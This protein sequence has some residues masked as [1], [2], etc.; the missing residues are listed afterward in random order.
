MSDPAGRWGSPFASRLGTW[1]R[2]IGGRVPVGRI[3]RR[4]ALIV[5]FAVVPPTLLEPGTMK[6][7]NS[8]TIFIAGMEYIPRQP[9]PKKRCE[10]KQ[11]DG[12]YAAW[13]LRLDNRRGIPEPGRQELFIDWQWTDGKLESVQVNKLDKGKLLHRSPDS[14]NRFPDW[15]AD[16]LRPWDIAAR[17]RDLGDQSSEEVILRHFCA[18]VE[19]QRELR[20][21]NTTFVAVD[22]LLARPGA[23]DSARRLADFVTVESDAAR[24]RATPN[25]QL[26][27]VWCAVD[28]RLDTADPQ[29]KNRVQ[30]AIL[31][32]IAD[33]IGRPGQPCAS[34]AGVPAWL[35]GLSG[36]LAILL[37]LAAA[38]LHHRYIRPWAL[39]GE[40][41]GRG[42]LPLLTALRRGGD[43]NDA[44]RGGPPANT[45]SARPAADQS[46][47]PPPAVPLLEGATKLLTR[48]IMPFPMD[49]LRAFADPDLEPERFAALKACTSIDM[50]AETLVTVFFEGLP[51]PP[52]RD[53][54]ENL[55]GWLARES[56]GRLRLVFPKR[57]TPIDDDWHTVV[58]Q[59]FDRGIRG[60]VLA[61]QCPGLARNGKPVHKAQVS[62]T[63]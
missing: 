8:A 21:L 41:G 49:A 19:A 53:H 33:G 46:S 24:A 12:L 18:L 32:R 3:G 34:V 6:G 7:P 23:P 22:A 43:W 2:V 62:I 39:L 58:H 55:D 10:K 11:F 31:R 27:A 47:R 26:R 40:K 63:L 51:Q 42:V 56:R 29:L 5:G 50:F 15:A 59:E 17:M 52:N 9:N 13:I 1:R 30:L 25:E 20:V 45:G 4:V 28:D 48:G 60:R 35:L 16:S 54:L 61:T 37:L 44:A 38:V 36:V 57:G 14:H